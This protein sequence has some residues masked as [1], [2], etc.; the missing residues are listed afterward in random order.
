M[1]EW[2]LT[3][4]VQYLVA[5]FLKN[6]LKTKRQNYRFLMSSLVKRFIVWLK[7]ILVSFSPTLAYVF[8]CKF[9]LHFCKYLFKFLIVSKYFN[10]NQTRFN[11]VKN[12]TTT[13]KQRKYSTQ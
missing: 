13:I 8:Q 3:W 12:N 9:M 7:K 5:F 1:Q 4:L 11:K 2:Y 10:I 6:S